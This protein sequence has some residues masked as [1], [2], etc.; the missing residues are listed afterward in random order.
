MSE[1]TDFQHHYVIR[2]REASRHKSAGT[3]KSVKDKVTD[4]MFICK[5]IESSE[6]RASNPEAGRVSS[7]WANQL[8]SGLEE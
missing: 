8:Y 6:Y 5:T 4:M 2:T 1:A 3:T 7:K